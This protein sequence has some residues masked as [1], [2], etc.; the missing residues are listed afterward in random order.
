MERSPRA[1]AVTFDRTSKR[2]GS[3]TALDDLRLAIEPGTLFAFVGPNGAGK[4]TTIGLL[5]GL[6][7]PS[8]GRVFIQGQDISSNPIETKREIGFVPDRPFLWP[9]W[10]PRETLRF[11]GTVFGQRGSALEA[12]IEEELEWFGLSD[13]A[14]QR[15]EALSHG[16]RQKVA[17]AQAFLHD[18]RLYV[19]DE[20]MVGLDP[21][22]QRR[23]VV[24]LR[25]KTRSGGTVFL[26]TH[27][28][29]LAEEISDQAALLIRGRLAA[30]GPPAAVVSDSDSGSLSEMFFRLTGTIGSPGSSDAG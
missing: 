30:S 10:T 23:L 24:R 21:I 8:S 6:L 13:V 18:P 12:R 11:V 2:Y 16:T 1:A 26:T 25:E 14:E 3:F 7:E 15:N 5:T 17:L 27:H 4:T 22:A 19:L 28:L 29:T 9:K 20:P